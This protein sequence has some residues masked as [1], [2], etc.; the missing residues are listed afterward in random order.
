MKCIYCF[1]SRVRSDCLKKE[2]V[3]IFARGRAHSPAGLDSGWEINQ[4]V[5]S[6]RVL[7]P[8]DL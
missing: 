2:F 5:I 4:T 1:V 7:V 8:T 6:I 3:V